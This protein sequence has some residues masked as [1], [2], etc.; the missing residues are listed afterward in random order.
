MTVIS[1]A[2]DRA[3]NSFKANA[4]KNKALIDELHNRSAKAR[5]GGSQ[6]AR[7]RHTCKGKLLPRDRIQLLIDAGSPFLEIG[8]LAANGMY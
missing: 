2:I 8:T 7:E 1:T 5:E 4:S 3:S 6:T